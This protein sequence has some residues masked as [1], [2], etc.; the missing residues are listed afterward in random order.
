MPVA[1]FAFQKLMGNKERVLADVLQLLPYLRGISESLQREV[2]Q[3]AICRA[4]CSLQ[5]VNLSPIALS[6]HSSL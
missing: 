2:W 4:C 5:M 6:V 3:R 1:R